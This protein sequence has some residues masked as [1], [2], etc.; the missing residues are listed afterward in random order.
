[1]NF[2]QRITPE[3]ARGVN[4]SLQ[5]F[6]VGEYTDCPVFDGLIDFCKLYT[7]CSIGTHRRETDGGYLSEHRRG[8]LT[9][10][11]AVVVA[12]CASRRCPEAEPQ[13]DGHR[14]ELVR[15]SAP[16]QEGRGLGL[17]LHQR[18]RAGHPGCVRHTCD[19]LVLLVR[20]GLRSAVADC[21]YWRLLLV[22]QSC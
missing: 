18:H 11:A 12:L 16:R 4:N 20:F 2:L 6:N 15:R 1:M 5:K 22:L 17:L 19:S 14:R 7:G 3:T 21:Q 8:S 10:A 9:V 13:G